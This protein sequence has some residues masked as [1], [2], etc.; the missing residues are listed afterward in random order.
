MEYSNEIRLIALDLDGTL[1]NDEKVITPRTYNALMKA[2]QRGV[3]LC[4][5]SG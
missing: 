3:R 2:Q 5:A 1:T 4:L